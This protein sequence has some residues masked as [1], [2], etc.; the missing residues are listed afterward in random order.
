MLARK[1]YIHL[2]S[3]LKSFLHCFPLVENICLQLIA[4][5]SGIWNNLGVTKIQKEQIDCSS[6]S[7]Q[8]SR[9]QWQHKLHVTMKTYPEERILKHSAQNCAEWASIHKSCPLQM[10]LRKLTNSPEEQNTEAQRQRMKAE[11]KKEEKTN[12]EDGYIN[13]T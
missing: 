1:L 6:V 7:E 9:S 2:W 12:R 3:R 8:E 13:K 5:S 4:T 10:E 11:R